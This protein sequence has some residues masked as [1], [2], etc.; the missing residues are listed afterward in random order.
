[1]E[2]I[3][4]NDRMPEVGVSVLVY[5]GVSRVCSLSDAD[6]LKCK[7]WRE[8][9]GSLCPIK[10]SESWK[11]IPLPPKRSGMTNYEKLK[12]RKIDEVADDIVEYM[13]CGECPISTCRLKINDREF[14][15]CKK[16]VKEWL[17][18][19]VGTRVEII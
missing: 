12:Q 7:F 5:D 4:V 3:S 11:P 1:M 14:L 8:E 19:E 2:W 13:K 6:F 10:R 16:E 17:E 15:C 18:S 9:N